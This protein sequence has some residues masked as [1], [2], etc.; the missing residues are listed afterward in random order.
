[1][2]QALVLALV[3]AAALERLIRALLTLPRRG[4]QAEAEQRLARG[5]TESAE[6]STKKKREDF[7]F[8]AFA[9]ILTVIGS[10]RQKRELPRC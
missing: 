9:I 10:F 2:L 7:I 1:M 5:A 4:V 6:L 3:P 8:F